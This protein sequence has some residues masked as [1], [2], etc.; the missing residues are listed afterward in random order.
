MKD[1]SSFFLFLLGAFLFV[2]I[3]FSLIAAWEYQKS[4]PLF[5]EVRSSGNSM[6]SGDAHS[7]TTFET[8]DDVRTL[9]KKQRAILTSTGWIDKKSGLIHIPIEKA[10]QIKAEKK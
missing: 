3:G 7:F 6:S 4:H 2:L 10:M 8:G 9:D 5:H 1:K